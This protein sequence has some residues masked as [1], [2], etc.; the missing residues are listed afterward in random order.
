M[1][2]ANQIMNTDKGEIMQYW[3]IGDGQ[4]GK[5]IDEFLKFGIVA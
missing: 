3:T 5:Y 4:G 2:K 1:I